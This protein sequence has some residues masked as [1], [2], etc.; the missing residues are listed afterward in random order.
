M[1]EKNLLVPG[2]VFSALLLVRVAMPSLPVP[3]IQ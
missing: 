1:N 3:A 2:L